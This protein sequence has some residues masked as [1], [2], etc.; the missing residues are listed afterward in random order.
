MKSGTKRRPWTARPFNAFTDLKVSFRCLLGHCPSFPIIFHDFPAQF[1]KFIWATG[2]P[3]HTTRQ[4]GVRCTKSN[5]V[6]PNLSL[7][8][9]TL[10]NPTNYNAVFQTHLSVCKN[11]FSSQSYTGS[12]FP[13][14]QCMSHPRRP[15]RQPW[16]VRPFQFC[17]TTFCSR[18][19]FSVRSCRHRFL[20]PKS[21]T[22]HARSWPS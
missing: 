12:P 10:R 6:T 1:S 8:I 15:L 20:N 21:C 2:C 16:T 3:V 11:L 7:F 4:L 5:T 9:K 13:V 19:G 18:I 17:W 22:I 14:D